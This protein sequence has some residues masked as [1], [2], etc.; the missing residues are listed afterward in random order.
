LK[1]WAELDVRGVSSGANGEAVSAWLL[2]LQ[3]WS[4][5][6]S[7]WSCGSA[8]LPLCHSSFAG[9]LGPAQPR[10]DGG[11]KDFFVNKYACCLHACLVGE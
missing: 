3:A 4:P 10:W 2:Q 9:Q 6:P 1:V 5:G 8:C 11:D 7:S